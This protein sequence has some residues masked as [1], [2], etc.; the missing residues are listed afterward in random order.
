MQVFFFFF[1]FFFACGVWTAKESF[2]NFRRALTLKM[3]RLDD[4]VSGE[5]CEE[6]T[7]NPKMERYTLYETPCSGLSF[8]VYCFYIFEFW[9]D[10][11]NHTT[12]KVQEDLKTS[13]TEKQRPWCSLVYKCVLL[14]FCNLTKFQLNSWIVILISISWVM[15]LF[16][17]L[18]LL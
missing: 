6:I 14:L 4:F 12:E 5:H 11:C 8:R 13:N 17:I 7:K 2:A 18:Y 15:S 1:F 9:G 3:I 10:H 16:V